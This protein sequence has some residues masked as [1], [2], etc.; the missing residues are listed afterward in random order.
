MA[1]KP[2]NHYIFDETTKM[3]IDL[4]SESSQDGSTMANDDE[5]D[6]KD[7]NENVSKSAD[8]KNPKNPVIDLTLE[9]EAPPL[10]KVPFKIIQVRD[11]GL[12]PTIDLD[13]TEK[14]P[15]VSLDRSEVPRFLKKGNY[16][17]A[18]VESEDLHRA[19]DRATQLRNQRSVAKAELKA[20]AKQTKKGKWPKVAKI[21]KAERALSAP[22][23]SLHPDAPR[24]ST[25]K[26]IG[27][28]ELK[29]GLRHCTQHCSSFYNMNGQPS[30]SP[31]TWPDHLSWVEARKAYKRNYDRAVASHPSLA[32]DLQH[33]SVY[34]TFSIPETEDEI[35]KCI[36]ITDEAEEDEEDG[37]E[38]AQRIVHQEVFGDAE[39]PEDEEDEIIPVE[40]LLANPI[41]TTSNAGQPTRKGHKIKTI[42]VAFPMDKYG[43]IIGHGITTFQQGINTDSGIEACLDKIARQTALKYALNKANIGAKAAFL[44]RQEVAN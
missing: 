12:N 35:V 41:P 44:A 16:D 15:I 14:I 43:S 9:E 10:T 32:A 31:G 4:A 27:L 5:K 23:A 26:R 7:E 36:Q 18:V 6:E 37:E 20:R 33:P 11:S 19:L 24:H 29:D 34:G 21:V 13:R 30:L 42:G 1:D 38:E 2:E 39:N 3:F 28:E 40:E 25:P 8:D 17:R 22:V